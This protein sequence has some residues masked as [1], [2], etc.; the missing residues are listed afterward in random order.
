MPGLAGKFKQLDGFASSFEAGCKMDTIGYI[1]FPKSAPSE[2]QLAAPRL[3]FHYANIDGNTVSLAQVCPQLD[4]WLRMLVTL[5]SCLPLIQ[6]NR[7]PYRFGAE[8]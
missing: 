5:T 8:S 3:E 7:T 6:D 4:S 2:N 1:S